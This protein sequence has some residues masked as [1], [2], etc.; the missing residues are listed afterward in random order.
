MVDVSKKNI[1][2][3]TARAQARLR[4]PREVADCFDGTDITVKKGAVFQTARVAGIMAAKRTSELIPMCHPLAIE[5][6]T[7]DLRM[8]G[9]DEIAIECSVAIHHKTCVS[10]RASQY[11]I[12][13]EKGS[14]ANASCRSSEP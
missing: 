4:V 11:G 13:T 1:T 6:C 10:S 7:V 8:E 14:S 2:R 12:S 5:H 9:C 3:R